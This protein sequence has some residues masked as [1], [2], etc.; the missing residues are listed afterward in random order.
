LVLE[1]R[2]LGEYSPGE[3]VAVLLPAVLLTG[4]GRRRRAACSTYRK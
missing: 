3:V 4:D 1:Y 2:I